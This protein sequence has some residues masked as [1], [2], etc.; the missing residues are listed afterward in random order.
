M[1]VGERKII[2]ITNEDGQTGTPRPN[3]KSM[4]CRDP[5]SVSSHVHRA[6]VITIVGWNERHP[7]DTTKR[8]RRGLSGNYGII[9]LIK[10]HFLL[11]RRPSRTGRSELAKAVCLLIY[12]SDAFDIFGKGEDSNLQHSLDE[13]T[14]K[15]TNIPL[16]HNGVKNVDFN[17]F[18]PCVFV[19]VCVRF[20]FLT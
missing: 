6:R 3:A 20:L 2:K 14:H 10:T 15:C 18:P 11:H 4:A 12:V 5:A 13:A 16:R 17:D 8:V 19:C 1:R 7:K 9:F